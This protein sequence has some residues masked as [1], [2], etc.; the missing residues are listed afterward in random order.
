MPCLIQ[1]DEGKPSQIFQLG[2]KM[3]MVGRDYHTE[4][5]ADDDSVSR[6]HAAIFFDGRNYFVRDNGSRNGT[7]V[8]D[9]RV[10]SHILHH[11][12]VVRFGSCHFRV[13]LASSMGRSGT[14]VLQVT[15]E[16]LK[17]KE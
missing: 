6:N 1:I 15:S 10:G 9:K 5:R 2:G 11:N 16:G 3:L 4:I 14:R 12:D 17:P 8:N 7:F 13:D